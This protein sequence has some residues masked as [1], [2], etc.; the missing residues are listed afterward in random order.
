MGKRKLSKQPFWLVILVLLSLK[1]VFVLIQLYGA[2]PQILPWALLAPIP[3]MIILAASFLFRERHHD[4]GLI[5]IHS[6]I[7]LLLF[8]DV[9]YSRAFGHL[10]SVRMIFAKGV[11]GDL[12]SSITSLLHPVDFLLLV[13]L[14]ILIWLYLARDRTARVRRPSAR[15]VALGLASVLMMTGY[16]GYQYR[17]GRMENYKYYPLV[18]SPMGDHL[19]DIARVSWEA[20]YQPTDEDHERIETWHEANRN[21]LTADPRYAGLAGIFRGKNL[22]VLQVESLEESLL[23]LTWQGQAITPNLNALLGESLRFDHVVEQVRDGNSSDAE[24]LF[25]SSLYP[26]ASGSAF[27]RFGDNSWNALPNILKG[28]GYTSIALHGDE[29]TYWNRDQV[30]ARMGF[31]RYVDETQFDSDLVSEDPQIGMGTLDGTLFRQGIREIE[32]L[33]EPFHAFLIT[34]TSHMPFTMPAA[35]HGLNLQTDQRTHDYLQSIH[36]VDRVFGEFYRDLKSRGLLEDS[37][38]VIYGDH[39]GVHKYYPTELP[40]N[41]KRVPF[42]IHA[43]GLAG[44]VI[45]N[46]GGQVDMLPTLLYLLG[47]DEA[48]YSGT[49][50][51]R[52][53]LGPVSGSPILPTGEI[54]FE[55][56]GVPHLKA[57]LP[58]SDLSIRIDHQRWREQEPRD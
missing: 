43:P 21:Y 27:L 29:K 9:I 15:W 3:L 7:S 38:L 46:P 40:D 16:T 42:L 34:I 6:L 33:P 58:V 51:G 22:I 57:A 11:S 1:S 50:M 56:Q 39:E 28:S 25:Q 47:Q 8:A 30:F 12:S 4:P 13:D 53:L 19:H 44:Q 36:Y 31:D 41:D 17:A 48:L 35:Y 23:G 20:A 54:R 45:A 14:P 32:A 18:L 37:V 55:A 52:N 2:S 26:V 49:V 24:L 5:L 10:F